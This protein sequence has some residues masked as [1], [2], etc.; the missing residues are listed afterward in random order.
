[1]ENIE[2][3]L[4]PR[5]PLTEEELIE[6]KYKQKR[7]E[8]KIARARASV[9]RLETTNAYEI[10]ENI[11]FDYLGDTMF[12]DYFTEA[13]RQLEAALSD[14]LLSD[15]YWE[16]RMKEHNALTPKQYDDYLKQSASGQGQPT[17]SK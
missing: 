7:R 16:K 17:E 6:R 14:F 13:K 4:P 3:T 10:L 12:R 9:L 2:T 15:T 5:Q 11:R 1:M 8:I